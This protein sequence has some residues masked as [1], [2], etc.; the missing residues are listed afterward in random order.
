MSISVD[1]TVLSF[2]EVETTIAW[3]LAHNERIAMVSAIDT[4]ETNTIEIV[5]TLIHAGTSQ[6]RELRLLLDRSSP[7]LSSLAHLDFSIGRFE[8]EIRDNFGVVLLNHPLPQR[9]A[10]HAH[11]PE[12]YFPLRQ[13]AG[14]LDTFPE[15]TGNYPFVEVAGESIYE[16]G[17]G[18]VHAGMI[19]PGHFRFSAVG[20]SIITMKARLWFVHRGIEKLLEGQPTV[21]AVRM[22]ERVSGDTSFGHSLAF[23]MAVEDALGIIPDRVTSLRRIL[24]LEMERTH[25]LISDIGAIAND[26]G[27]G[28]INSHA[29]VLRESA[30]RQ[31][32]AVAGHRL[33]RGTTMP[34]STVLQRL[35]DLE[36]LSAT[37]SNIDELVSLLLGNAIG[38]DRLRGT[39]TLDGRDANA[40]GCVGYVAEASG[41]GFSTRTPFRSEVFL[42]TR[43]NVDAGDVAARFL[44]RVHH[45]SESFRIQR[46][47]GEELGASVFEV[48]H[49]TQSALKRRVAFSS[50]VGCIEGWRGRIAHRVIIRDDRVIRAK[51]VDPSFFNWP[52]VS[53]ASRGA[54]V[55]DFPLINKSFNL[56]YAGNDL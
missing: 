4:P 44:V 9:L 34:G 5:Y 27:L 33:L 46:L 22:A 26:V 50:G 41:V 25:N 54:M 52:S 16:I 53:V 17:V 23:T 32:E 10:K 18:P 13:D 7:R 3:A 12:E 49:P 29:L 35:P 31:N 1:S 19:E 11:W 45:L 28:I 48:C 38:A 2:A 47:L 43:T 39:G 55:A 42:P 56:S 14:T 24:L 21:A 37:E 15:A 6:I 51:I 40:M 30:L 20:E 8:R 36:W